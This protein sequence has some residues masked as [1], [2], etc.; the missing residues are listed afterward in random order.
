M[1][2]EE[3]SRSSI[4][5]PSIDSK[6]LSLDN[7]TCFWNIRA[8][9]R[10][11]N[12]TKGKTE[13]QLEPSL[14]N[15]NDLVELQQ[16]ETIAINDTA[17]S[18]INIDFDMN[19]LT[20]IVGSVGSGKSALLQ[21]LI[22]ELPVA[23]GRI[24]RRYNSLAYSPQDPWIMNGTIRENIV[25]GSSFDESFY[26]QVVASCGLTYDFFLFLQGDKTLV[27][28]RG[29]QLSG[30]QRARISLARAL[31]RNADVLLLDDPLSAVDAKVG[32]L[33]FY[34]AIQ[35]LCLKRGKCVI[36]GMYKTCFLWR[37]SN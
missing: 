23:T 18:H 17:L 11:S 28:D 2:N 15:K 13:H 35:D 5:N 37:S 20:F 10:Q 19:T 30:G 34:S 14:T 32:R 1:Y 4:S 24:E 26:E 27:G 33:I 7:V 29:V 16:E 12:I 3:S 31:Y 22:G 9:T 6:V 25:M 36:L 8:S 21:A